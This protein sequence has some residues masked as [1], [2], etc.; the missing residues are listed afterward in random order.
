MGICLQFNAL[1]GRTSGV[2]RIAF[3]GETACRGSAFRQSLAMIGVYVA[4][5]DPTYHC[6]RAE[7]AIQE[8]KRM[9]ARIQA[10]LLWRP[11]GIPRAYH[12]LLTHCCYIR[13]HLVRPG[14]DPSGI[15]PYHELTGSTRSWRGCALLP[16]GSVVS[17]L[18]TPFELRQAK[19]VGENPPLHGELGILL[20]FADLAGTGRLFYKLGTGETVVRRNFSMI[21]AQNAIRLLPPRLLASDPA[22]LQRARMHYNMSSP[23]STDSHPIPSP[24]PCSDVSPSTTSTLPSSVGTNSDNIWK[25]V[26]QLTTGDDIVALYKSHPGEFFQA[27]VIDIDLPKKQATIRY[28]VRPGHVRDTVPF[29]DIKS[30]ANA[31]T[32]STTLMTQRQKGAYA[33]QPQA[34]IMLDPSGNEGLALSEYHRQERRLLEI[35]A[36]QNSHN[37]VHSPGHV[38]AVL[39]VISHMGPQIERKAALTAAELRAVLSHLPNQVDAM[40]HSDSNFAYS[41]LSPHQHNLIRIPD[42]RNGDIWLRN[43]GPDRVEKWTEDEAFQYLSGQLQV[44]IS[45]NPRLAYLQDDNER[46]HTKSFALSPGTPAVLLSMNQRSAQ[47]AIKDTDPHSTDAIDAIQ[48][49][50]D[51]M[52]RN[53][54]FSAPFTYE[55]IPE[56]HRDTILRTFMFVVDKY[57][58][59]LN[60]VKSKARLVADGSQQSPHTHG[61][62]ASPVMS[63]FSSKM[64]LALAARRGLKIAA[65][66]IREA[67]CQVPYTKGRRCFIQVPPLLRKDFGRYVEL[68]K[69]LY[70]TKN[71]AREFYLMITTGLIRHGYEQCDM[72]PAL[73]RRK[74]PITG[75]YLYLGLHVDDSLI[76]YSNDDQLNHL[77]QSLSEIFGPDKVKLEK[78]PTTFLG[79][80]IHYEEDHAISIKQHGF[81][82]SVSERFQDDLGTAIEMYPHSGNELKLPTQPALLKPLTDC[83]K[84]KYME[85]VGCLGY[86]T[87]TRS[88]IQAQLTYLQSRIST[89]CLGDWLRALKVLRYLKCTS[90]YAITFPGPCSPDAS[91]EEIQDRNRLW[92]TVNASYA[93]CV[94][95]RGINAITIS[96]GTYCPP[97]LVKAKKQGAISRS[98]CESEYSGY[99]DATQ[100]LYYARGVG[101]FFHCD[102]SS[103]T[104]LENDNQAALTLASSPMI[105]KGVRHNDVRS[106]FFKDAI[107]RGI[108]QPVWRPTHDLLADFPTKPVMG[109]RFHM[110]DSWYRNGIPWAHIPKLP[111]QPNSVFQM[112]ISAGAEEVLKAIQ[113]TQ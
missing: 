94:D 89:P 112:G 63:G 58:A 113:A 54:V 42:D 109:P 44:R 83:Q 51:Q 67:F 84:Q 14:H 80:S 49:E 55:Q 3:D 103:P 107:L 2:R 6:P 38:N 110:L 82:Q 87:L 65:I 32:T 66:D 70:G 52:I 19:S 20:G 13:A 88:A 91:E 41:S 4:P 34:W 22:H 72:D 7:R 45:S 78:Q 108:V 30:Q 73:L 86:A 59:D 11:T 104:I 31:E 29:A 102:I 36:L 56:T 57:D 79:M 53:E 24:V 74:D 95:G 62:T 69:C 23:V 71:A 47:N 48:A 40:T 17:A 25:P 106:H 81:I 43:Q 111:V 105:G 15:T 21:D 75:K 60:Y 1:T 35:D 93:S 26:H 100:V 28:L 50:C 18:R 68:L 27:R 39:P 5:G 76:I 8:I 9:A 85:L 101:D 98:S 12:H 90:E 96:L 16:Y 99:G 33:C 61:P 64:M 77:Y 97:V 10:M 46:D 92:A 37:P